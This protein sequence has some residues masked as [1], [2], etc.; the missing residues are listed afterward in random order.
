MM[1]ETVMIDLYL[2]LKLVS[3]TVAIWFITVNCG[4]IAHGQAVSAANLVIMSI[5]ITA[6]IYAMGWL[7]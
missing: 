3:L 1:M 4:E 6:F 2:I 5:A 7:S